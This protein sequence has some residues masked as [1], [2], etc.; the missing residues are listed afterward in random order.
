MSGRP[1]NCTPVPPR[2]RS[3]PVS[4]SGSDPRRSRPSFGI[5]FPGSDTIATGPS[6]G[7]V[8]SGVD[9][10]AEP[11]IEMSGQLPAL[12]AVMSQADVKS[13][14]SAPITLGRNTIVSWIPASSADCL[15]EVVIGGLVDGAVKPGAPSFAENSGEN[16]TAAQLVGV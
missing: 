14:G 4:F 15:I 11:M 10:S 8:S 3:C 12:N 7:T 9:A 2:A 13:A 5:G 1:E 6:S 16:G